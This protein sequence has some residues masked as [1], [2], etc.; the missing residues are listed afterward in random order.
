MK[1][2]IRLFLTTVFVTF[3]LNVAQAEQTV[4]KDIMQGYE[5]VWKIVHP[6]GH[7]G[8]AFFIGPNQ[9]VT[10]T[11]N[12][13]GTGKSK[14]RSNKID[15]IY[16]EQRDQKLKLRKVLNI[17]AVN[18]LAVLETE[19]EVS[20]YLNISKEEPS[21]RLFALGYSQGVK[22]TL[23]HSEKYGVFDNGYGYDMSVDKVMSSD[24]SNFSGGVHGGPVVN[25]Q[26]E[27]VGVVFAGS[28]N[29]TTLTVN[30]VSTL[31]ALQGGSIGVD[32][33][34]FIFS[35]CI[36]KAINDLN[37][38]ADQEGDA[39]AQFMASSMYFGRGMEGMKPDMK[40]AIELLS[41][42]ADQGYALAQFIRGQMALMN[43]DITVATEY[44]LKSAEQGNFTP[45]QMMVVLYLT[46]VA[47]KKN[48]KEAFDLLSRVAEKGHPEA[49]Y[50]LAM[51]YYNG[52]GV[53]QDKEK[54]IEL[55][56]ESAD[57]GYA[58][59]QEALEDMQVD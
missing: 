49:Q 26:N 50:A 52:Q 22:Q 24:R 23:I 15:A 1:N 41:K 33:S 19:G 36:E 43:R 8:T 54:A 12:I 4:P 31:E 34:E 30:N 32:C 38:K 14:S 27:V 17:S 11:Y 39:L 58:P 59:A 35:V 10:H 18:G 45:A 55:M 46:R 21:G 9:V 29:T 56:S 48:L 25:A 47:G 3:V 37:E 16:L 5:A 7:E 13:T 51:M 42:S 20:N 28:T 44:W 53:E 2:Y 40:K 57:Q 6:E